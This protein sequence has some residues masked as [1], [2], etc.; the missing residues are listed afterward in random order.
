MFWAEQGLQMFSIFWLSSL[1]FLYNLFL[2]VKTKQKKTKKTRNINLF[3]SQ[4]WI[5]K[6]HA[7]RSFWYHWIVWYQ[8][9]C[10]FNHSP[11]DDCGN[12]NTIHC[13]YCHGETLFYVFHFRRMIYHLKIKVHHLN[14]KF[15]I[16]ICHFLNY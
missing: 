1:M 15:I 13:S 5:F 3:L 7:F 9:E 11:Y 16:V 8:V 6:C 14:N 2:Y 10:Y 4:G 12:W